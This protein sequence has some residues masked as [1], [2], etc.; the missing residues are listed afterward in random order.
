MCFVETIYYGGTALKKN[1]LGI[2]DSKGISIGIKLMI[3]IFLLLLIVCSTLT[4]ISYLKSSAEMKKSIQDNLTNSVK[5]NAELFAQV[6]SQRKVEV[7][8]LGRREGITSMN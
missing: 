6:L 4:I 7:E 8:T 3:Q 2:R 5:N 1:A